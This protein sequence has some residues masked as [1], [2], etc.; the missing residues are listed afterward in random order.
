MEVERVALHAR[1]LGAVVLALAHQSERH[2]EACDRY[3]GTRDDPRDRRAAAILVDLPAAR[4]FER[5]IAL[6]AAGARREPVPLASERAQPDLDRASILRVWGLLDVLLIGL[7]RPVEIPGRLE[8]A[9]EVEEEHRVGGE[10][11]RLLEQTRGFTELSVVVEVLAALEELHGALHVGVASVLGRRTIPYTPDEGQAHA[12]EDQRQS[13]DSS[14]RPEECTIDRHEVGIV[15]LEG[16]PTQMGRYHIVG[17]LASGGMAEILLGK[18]AGPGG[19]ERAVVIK[20][21]HP[22]L[23]AEPEFLKMFLDEARIISRIQHPNV[24]QVMEL[25][26]EDDELFMAMEYLAGESLL[27]VVRRG[28]SKKR[29]LPRPLAAHVMAKVCAGLHA[30]HELTD[31]EGNPLGLVHRDISP[32]NIF[33]TYDGAVKLL[34]FGIAKFAER[35]SQTQAGQ[36]KGKFSYMSPEQCRGGAIDRRSD[37]FSLGTVLFEITT[38]KRL[39]SR[40]TSLATLK[41]ICDDP[42][43]W[44]SQID[45]RYPPVLEA[46]VKRALA[47]DVEDRYQTA[48][49]M[50]RDLVGAVRSLGLDDVPEDAL[51]DYLRELFGDRI[52][53]KRELLRRLGAGSEITDVPSPEADSSIELPIADTGGSPPSDT[54]FS[55]EAEILPP[56]ASQREPQ[57]WPWL[58]LGAGVLFGAV[59]GAVLGTSGVRDTGE[60]DRQEVATAAGTAT[61]SAPEPEPERA[62]PEATAGPGEP[63]RE[64]ATVQQP[65]PEPPEVRIR[66][67]SVPPLARIRVDGIERGTTPF[68]LTFPRSDTP[69]S[70]ELSRPGYET[71]TTE[72]VPDGNERV[73]AA[74]ARTEPEPLRTQRTRRSGTRSPST[75]TTPTASETPMRSAPAEPSM[76]SPF[77][78][79]Q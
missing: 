37:I 18:I 12:A 35:V 24:V 7:D 50:R 23:A 79:F 39:F 54:P 29:L 49:E 52:A 5:R 77:R 1:A 64:S 20:R 66:V 21:I 32:Q 41:A 75:G 58:A 8:R 40:D 15:V 53:E 4:I 25:G 46:V 27:G 70:L 59:A 71:W 56:P 63:Q 61:P 78:R 45:R 65:E 73:S 33:I 48:A 34:D 42:I 68:T 17:Q 38:G 51:G 3:A 11:V 14:H 19:F 44:P 43:R 76:A 28:A 57:R 2:A 6:V 13:R 10:V 47:R 22:H 26:R 69:V 72:L 55:A 9:A 36:L 16:A 31:E 74:L 60:P 67:T 62:A 30:A